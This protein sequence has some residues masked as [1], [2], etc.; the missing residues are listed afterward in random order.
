MF[1]SVFSVTGI[2]LAAL[3]LG[4]GAPVGILAW[5][6]LVAPMGGAWMGR[7]S[8]AWRAWTPPLAWGLAL[9]MT[10]GLPMP[11]MAAL[12]VA[13]LYAIGMGIGAWL[14][15]ERAAGSCFL[16]VAAL[17]LAPTM[18]GRLE[19][20]WPPAVSAQLLN[21]SPVA[22]S[23]EGAGV[24]WMRHPAVYELAGTAN[25]DP[26]MRTQHRNWLAAATLLVL[27]CLLALLA[28]P[29]TQGTTET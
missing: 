15:R 16:L 18:G 28:K 26:S 1:T 8:R 19:R 4:F 7:W 24:D 9:M 25:I 6:P 22:W 3:V 12:F 13:S 14:P 21:V 23:L 5:L 11:W 29:R 17:S 10:R 2:G 20:P 27:G